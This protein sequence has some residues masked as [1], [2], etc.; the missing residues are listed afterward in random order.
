MRALRLLLSGMVIMALLVGA[1]AVGVSAQ[2]EVSQ[3]LTGLFTGW[4]HWVPGD[5]CE[6][7]VTTITDAQGDTNLGKAI[8]HS[9]HCP[10][11][12]EAPH[13]GT[14]SLYFDDASTLTGTYQVTCAMSLPEGPSVMTCTSAGG[15]VTGGTGRFEGATGTIG[16]TTVLVWFSGAWGPLV[17]VDWI[18]TI[19]GSLTMAAPAPMESP[20]A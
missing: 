19:D 14:S 9:E 18:G 10:S 1:G 11:M 3:P 2:E 8:V 4:M 16:F 6:A 17:G 13:S 15:E 5:A 20:A 12:T 7:G